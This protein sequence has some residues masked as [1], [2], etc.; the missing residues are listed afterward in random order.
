[1]TTNV[2]EI[3][4]YISQVKKQLVCQRKV[5]KQIIAELKSEIVGFS[6]EKGEVDYSLICK[7]FGKPEELAKVYFCDCDVEKLKRTMKIKNIVVTA[8]VIVAL[9]IYA[10]VAVFVYIDTRP[11]ENGYLIEKNVGEALVIE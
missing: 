7:Q 1:M 4:K 2:K 8:I 9:L 6:E 5:K 10:L 11:R 3:N